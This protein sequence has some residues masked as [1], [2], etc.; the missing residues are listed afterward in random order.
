M[1]LLGAHRFEDEIQVGAEHLPHSAKSLL[2][3]GCGLPAVIGLVARLRTAVGAEALVLHPIGRQA[4]L[5]DKF[6]A[7]INLDAIAVLQHLHL[8][9]ILAW[10]PVEVGVDGHVAILID[11][12][13]K[14]KIRCRQMRRQLGEVGL[15]VLEGLGGDQPALAD[16]LVLHLHRR[17]LKALL[18]PVLQCLETTTWQEVRLHREE[19]PFVSGLSVSMADLVALETEAVLLREGRHLRND[20]RVLAAAPKTRQAGVVDDTERRGVAP[21][22]QRFMKE[23]LHVEAVEGAVEL[24][25]APLG[26]TQVEN[27]RDDARASIAKAHL[28]DRG[29]VLH[30]GTRLIRHPITA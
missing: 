30:L 8:G 4:I 14:G 26:V 7:P 19:A 10:H 5:C 1:P 27:A 29:I 2:L 16:G 21:E 17:P 12:P 20:H 13:C 28:I 25:V 18:V 6:P 11:P 23:A 3:L 15:L 24:E 22:C 9:A